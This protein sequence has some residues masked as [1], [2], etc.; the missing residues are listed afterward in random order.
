[1]NRLRE[2]R[3]KQSEAELVAG[4]NMGPIERREQSCFPTHTRPRK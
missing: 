4:R 1:L 2:P 3:L